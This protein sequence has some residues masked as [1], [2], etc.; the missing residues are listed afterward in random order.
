[1]DNK[2]RINT[3]R[4]IDDVRSFWE[5][6]SL[7]SGEGSFKPG[8][9][10]V[11]DNHRNTYFEDCFAGIFREIDFISTYSE[12]AVVLDLGCGTGFWTVEM[13]LRRKSGEFNSADLTEKALELTE[14]RLSLYNLDANL[15]IQNAE[16][17]TFPDQY[18]NHV[19]CQ[20][21]LHHTPDIEKALSEMYR[22]IKPGATASIS[23]YYK[24]TILKVWRFLYPV[25]RV[26][27]RLCRM[28]IRGRGREYILIQKD[29]DE[30]VRLYEGVDNPI[31]RAFSKS[32]IVKLI[33][34][35]FAIKRS[36]L[37]FFH[38]RFLPIRLPKVV[39]QILARICGFMIHLSLIRK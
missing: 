5:K 18:F 17:M 38:A 16:A 39:H 33:E 29:P 35:Y 34:T 21:V 24:N 8:S 2:K 13:L 30:I 26:L 28:N 19:N 20:G 9:K 7:F 10:E 32:K 25:G 22:I 4:T 15:S 12:N 23:V 1:M 11:F 3:Q 31:G 14:K 37:F 27:Y 6:N 36:F